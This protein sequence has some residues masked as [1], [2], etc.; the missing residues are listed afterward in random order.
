ME[1]E[2]G[3]E[4]DW[5]LNRDGLMMEAGP[6]Q[7]EAGSS[8]GRLAAYGKHIGKRKDLPWDGSRDPAGNAGHGLNMEDISG[9]Q[10]LPYEAA[11]GRGDSHD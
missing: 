7:A 8:G 10:V 9:K 4:Q 5:S 2:E 6:A 11:A 1:S 3:M